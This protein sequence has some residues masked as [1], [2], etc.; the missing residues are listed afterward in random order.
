MRLFSF[1]LDKSKVDIAVEV[2]DITA[3][4]V[5]AQGEALDINS[6]ERPTEPET[7]GTDGLV[8]V[9]LIKLAWGRSGD[10]GN[11]ANVGI[12]A[13]QPEYL[14]YIWAALTETTIAT[15]GTGVMAESM[16]TRTDSGCRS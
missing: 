9:P 2:G 8:E 15:V 5:D 1:A 10:K 7:P 13:R 16:I 6:I 14:P 12:I 3:E 11:K 4:S